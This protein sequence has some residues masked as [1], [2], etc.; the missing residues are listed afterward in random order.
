[1]YKI[2]I[3]QRKILLVL[4]GG[5]AL[6]LSS[7]PR[8][9]FKTFRTLQK[10]WKKINQQS[11]ERSFRRLAKEK[12]I[13]EKR[14]PDGSIKFILT[15]EGRMQ[16]KKLKFLGNSISFKKPQKWD[17]KWRIV[18][19]DIPEKER[20]FRAILREHLYNL[21]F[22]KL[23]QSVFVSPHPFE[24]PILEL[25]ALYSVQPYV[26]VI[27]ANKIDNELKLKKHF[28]KTTI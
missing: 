2:G 12:L 26:R 4:A 13:K 1:M 3:V 16:A 15:E 9:Y 8:Q 18:I 17:K 23:Q 19:F 11:F 22:F 25:V 5:V 27:T 14:L 24:K 7:S 6:G 28:F 21:K 20:L 10:D